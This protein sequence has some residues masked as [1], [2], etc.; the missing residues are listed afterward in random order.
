MFDIDIACV[1]SYSSY[2]P[3]VSSYSLSVSKSVLLKSKGW[4]SETVNRWWFVLA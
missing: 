3:S 1:G 2:S 4:L